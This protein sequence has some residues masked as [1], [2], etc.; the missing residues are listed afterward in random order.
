ML[1]FVGPPS[2]HIAASAWAFLGGAVGL[3]G[4][5]FFLEVLATKKLSVVAPFMSP[6]GM[7]FTIVLAVAVLREYTQWNIFHIIGICCALMSVAALT[8]AESK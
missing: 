3:V 8:L 4:G 6:F 7:V 5:Y 2:V 1:F